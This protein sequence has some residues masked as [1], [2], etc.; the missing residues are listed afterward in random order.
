M[1][2]LST[3]SL[4]KKYIEVLGKQMAYCEIGEAIKEWLALIPR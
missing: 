2:N 3:T 1:E 4:P